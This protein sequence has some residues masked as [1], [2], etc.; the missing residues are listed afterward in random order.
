MGLKKQVE[1]VYDWAC[2]KNY[3]CDTCR[4]AI[5]GGWNDYNDEEDYQCPFERVIQAIE[6]RAK[7]QEEGVML[8]D[9]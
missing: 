2:N 8:N 6:D 1:K 3:Y 5:D 7:E 9:E 4:Y